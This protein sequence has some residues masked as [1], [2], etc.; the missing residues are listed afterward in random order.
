MSIKPTSCCSRQIQKLT[1]QR[2]Q[3]SISSGQKVE[4][5]RQEGEMKM[6]QMKQQLKEE[7]AK[8]KQK[9]DE[10]TALRRYVCYE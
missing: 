1:D 4:K 6:L 5:V 10:I 2:V 3:Q 7:Q 9:A 8:S